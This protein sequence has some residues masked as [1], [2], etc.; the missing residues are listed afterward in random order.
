MMSSDHFPVADQQVNRDRSRHRMLLGLILILLLLAWCAWML[1]AR[2]SVYATTNPARVEVA[3]TAYI[4]QAPVSGKIA[5]SNLA[6]GA[7]VQTGDVRVE[8]ES[9]PQ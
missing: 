5:K 3:Q 4:V 9:E 8:L 6:L 7:W 2:I 1:W